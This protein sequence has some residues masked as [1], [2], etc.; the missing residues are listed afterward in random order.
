[1][2]N[3]SN[4]DWGLYIIIEPVWEYSTN[5]IPL[6]FNLFLLKNIFFYVFKSFWCADLE[7]NFFNIFLN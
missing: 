2:T 1:M 7:N 3:N 6:N 4:M 5:R